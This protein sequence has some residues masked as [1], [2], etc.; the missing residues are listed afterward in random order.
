[1]HKFLKAAGFSKFENERQIYEFIK[2]EVMRPERLTDRAPLAD[3]CSI[4]EYRWQASPEI[5]FCAGIL[6]FGTGEG[7]VDYYY[8]YFLTGET[9]SNEICS[10]ERY[11][12][13]ENYAGLID[14]YKIGLSLIFFVTNPL[15]YRKLPDKEV[16]FDFRGTSLT[17]F[18]N[19]ATVILPVQKNEADLEGMK[20][21]RKEQENLIEAARNGDEEAIETLTATDMDMYHQ[22]SKR[23]EHEDLYSVVEQSLMPSGIE[24]DQYSVIAE[25][26]SVDET[27]NAWSKDAIWLL[28]LSCNDVEFSAAVRKADLTGEP[29]VGRRLK[30]KIWMQGAVDFSQPV[31]E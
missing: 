2:N 7:R 5:G 13:R 19:E 24:C 12:E 14:E 21:F 1:M 10:V 8:P 9:S 17:A 23:I 16:Q 15:S 6:D 25:I 22:I 28:G 3:G 20:N 26:T 4:L 27:E 11:T 31:R 30:G 29:A 18:C